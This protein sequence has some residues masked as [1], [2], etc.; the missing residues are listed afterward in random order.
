MS[1][2]IFASKK[3]FADSMSEPELLGPE[4]PCSAGRA[5]R[6]II[7]HRQVVALLEES[8]LVVQFTKGGPSVAIGTLSLSP[9]P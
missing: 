2:G 5:R 9:V 6:G 7:Q 4:F 3:A 1:L 8:D